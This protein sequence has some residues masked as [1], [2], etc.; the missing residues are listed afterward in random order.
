MERDGK[1]LLSDWRVALLKAVG[2]TGSLSRAAERTGVPYRTA[3]QKLKEAED[4]LGVR[5][6]DTTSGGADGGGAELT[7]EAR[8]LI[9]RFERVSRGISDTV[10]RRFDEDLGDL[11]G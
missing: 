7:P 11:I 1:V 6:L 10:Q 2:E 4:E 5:L 3:W 8:D 9:A